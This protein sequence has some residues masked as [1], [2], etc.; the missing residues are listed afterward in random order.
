MAIF[1]KRS[2]VLSDGYLDNGYPNLSDGQNAN[3]FV[4]GGIRKT[5]AYSNFE[6]ATKPPFGDATLIGGFL[7]YYIDSTKDYRAEDATTTVTSGTEDG[8]FQV[9]MYHTKN[10][11]RSVFE[12]GSTAVANSDIIAFSSMIN[13][14]PLIFDD[15]TG[16]MMYSEP[17]VS[18]RWSEGIKLREAGP[19]ISVHEAWLA[20]KGSAQRGTAHKRAA[21]RWM[22]EEQIYGAY[23]YKAEAIGARKGNPPDTWARDVG[24]FPLDVLDAI[25]TPFLKKVPYLNQSLSGSTTWDR[26]ARIPLVEMKG[27]RTSSAMLRT[28]GEKV[29]GWTLKWGKK[30]SDKVTGK[31]RGLS[32]AYTDAEI[33]SVVQKKWRPKYGN[34]ILQDDIW[35]FDDDIRDFIEYDKTDVIEEVPSSAPLLNKPDPKMLMNEK[36]TIWQNMRVT[37]PIEFRL[38]TENAHDGNSDVDQTGNEQRVYI[39]Q[40]NPVFTQ[41]PNSISSCLW[42]NV[43]AYFSNE[44]DSTKILK[45]PNSEIDFLQEIRGQVNIPAPL[46]MYPDGDS[47]QRPNPYI[48]IPIRL[49]LPPPF[50]KASGEGGHASRLTCRRAAWFVFNRYPMSNT[51]DMCSWWYNDK[52]RQGAYGVVIMNAMNTHDAS[53]V[54]DGYYIVADIHDLVN[55]D[56]IDTATN[57]S[58]SRIVSKEPILDLGPG[59]DELDYSGSATSYGGT[60][61]TTDGIHRNVPLVA[62]GDTSLQSNGRGAT[63][64]VTISSGNVTDV[65]INKFGHYYDTGDYLTAHTNLAATNPAVSRNHHIELSNTSDPSLDGEII[66]KQSSGSVVPTSTTQI[67][68][69][70]LFVT[71]H[72]G[73]AR[74]TEQLAYLKNG[75]IFHMHKDGDDTKYITFLCK[76]DATQA[77]SITTVSVQAIAQSN[78]TISSVFSDAD[79]LDVTFRRTFT[80]QPKT[81]TSGKDIKAFIPKDS[82]TGDTTWADLKF[83]ATFDGVKMSLTHMVDDN[84]E[85]ILLAPKHTG[86]TMATPTDGEDFIPNGMQYV[87]LSGHIRTHPKTLM[88]SYSSTAEPVYY[89]G[90]HREWSPFR[91]YHIKS[92]F[93]GTRGSTSGD[94]PD[95]NIWSENNSAKGMNEGTAG[96]DVNQYNGITNGLDGSIYRG[97]AASLTYMWCPYFTVSLTSTRYGADNRGNTPINDTAN[98]RD[99]TGPLD[100]VSRLYMDSFTAA[101]FNYAHQN[102]TMNTANTPSNNLTIEDNTR[103]YSYLKIDIDGQDVPHEDYAADVHALGKSQGYISL[104]FKSKT[105]ASE[106]AKYFLMNGFFTTKHVASFDSLTTKMSYSSEMHPMGEFHP[107]IVDTYGSN[108]AKN[109]MD[110]KWL[111]H[112]TGSTDTA[113]GTAFASGYPMLANSPLFGEDRNHPWT[114][115]DDAGDGAY[116][117]TEGLDPGDDFVLDG[118]NGVDD[119]T[120]SGIFKLDWTDDDIT[121]LSSKIYLE[122]AATSQNDMF[123]SAN[124]DMYKFILSIGASAQNNFATAGKAAWG[125]MQSSR[126][127]EYYSKGD[128]TSVYG[129]GNV[130][131]LEW[132]APNL[133]TLAIFDSTSDTLPSTIRGKAVTIHAM[134][135]T[136]SFYTSKTCNGSPQDDA[137][138]HVSPG[139]FVR[140]ENPL[141]QA[142]ILQAM[143]AEPDV[144]NSTDFKVVLDDDS[145]MANADDELYIVYHAGREWVTQDHVGGSADGGFSADATDIIR[146]NKY[147]T[148]ICTAELQDDGSYL[149]MNAETATKTNPANVAC[150]DTSAGNLNDIIYNTNKKSTDGNS[151]FSTATMVPEGKFVNSTLCISPWR[152]WIYIKPE[153]AS[154]ERAFKSICQITSTVD[155]DFSE[156]AGNANCALKSSWVSGKRTDSHIETSPWSWDFDEQSELELKTDYGYGAYSYDDKKGGMLDTKLVGAGEYVDFNIQGLI[157]TGTLT[158]KETTTVVFMTPEEGLINNYQVAM[159]SDEGTNKP[160]IYTMFY[161]QIPDTPTDFTVKP[162][163]GK[164]FYP[165][166]TWSNRADDVWYGFLIVDDKPINNQYHG[167]VL[168]VPL[169][170]EVAS[171]SNTTYYRPDQ[172]Q[173][174]GTRDSN[175]NITQ[176]GYVD[177]VGAG[178]TSNVEGLSGYTTHFTS[179][180]NSHMTINEGRFTQ[181]T[182]E[183]S[184]SL[185]VSPDDSPSS[186]EYILEKQYEYY[187]FLDTNKQINVGVYPESAT[188][189]SNIA[190]ELK[191]TSSIPHDGETPTN[192]IVTLDTRLKSGNVKL[193]ID[194]KLEDQS[195]LR[196]ATG[197]KNNWPTGISLENY[198]SNLRIGASH[199]GLQNFDGKIEELVIYNKLIYP[200]TPNDEMFVFKK[201]VK[202]LT[203]ATEAVSRSYSGKLFIK[204]YHNIRGTNDKQVTST[205]QVSFRKAAFRLRTEN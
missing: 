196:K 20:Q 195:G 53:D 86:V 31:N 14:N 153:H 171:T 55:Q 51:H 117:N 126:G 106:S 28:A 2:K 50:V 48:H 156:A 80:C 91:K 175:G 95:H 193:Y 133:N 96:T 194:G 94:A 116:Q 74:G 11:I 9:D 190:V 82:I 30:I 142:R 200:V 158:E 141:V 135:N 149:L 145:I 157:S 154:V 26:N 33:G 203:G 152:Y 139:R 65:T 18:T 204:D 115:S 6:I 138:F 198:T 197:T 57:N 150:S 90:D 148:T 69:I 170:E 1:V 44:Q 27:H 114:S 71:D 176:T 19:S 155:S 124:N 119:F 131:L 15:F 132:V 46:E 79:E 58:D 125:L 159:H 97:P 40:S 111:E 128:G 70:K 182:T 42:E 144:D 36:N 83:H 41:D 101:R 100:S 24:N 104:G 178:V 12:E 127:T 205:P 147:V 187:I 167:A 146:Q 3:V 165:E 174:Y 110:D 8:K 180:S 184:I 123:N 121:E 35:F 73:G 168:H 177:G 7:S 179:A 17:T 107:Y 68:T 129:L 93:A 143:P 72:D 191:S 137:R 99:S 22:S 25:G 186:N 185:H 202:E 122:S 78:T 77:G 201:P 43:H 85:S 173:L 151:G 21:G 52:A 23:A 76:S 16:S 181:P 136:H 88:G 199:A 192:I 49:E 87:S 160:Y 113:F 172:G 92:A 84:V 56:D 4:R 5:L 112:F 163:E 38:E 161:D 59:I 162:Q 189:S 10:N 47:Q 105:E 81:V 164:E 134:D 67:A 140:R 130:S 108:D 45:A 62:V 39:A 188:E 118:N 60:N 37:S 13:E 63:A 61:Y 102:A 169:D 109:G 120:Q 166:F 75:H 66:F 89:T 32:T 29:A 103:Q 54:M 183:M 64:D 98:M 34:Q